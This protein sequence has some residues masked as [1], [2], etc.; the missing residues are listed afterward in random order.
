MRASQG[1]TLLE[2]V[3]VFALMMGLMLLIT[4]FFIKGQRYATASEAYGSTQRQATI[5]LGR[6]VDELHK[7]SRLHLMVGPSNDEIAAISFAD[8]EGTGTGTGQ[9]EVQFDTSTGRLVWKK[10]VAFYHDEPSRQVRR[11]ETPLPS[12]TTDLAA[13]PTP[14]PDFPSLRSNPQAKP[15]GQDVRDFEVGLTATGASL[16]VTVAKQ[17]PLTMLKEAEKDVSVTVRMDIHMLD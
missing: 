14:L 6:I 5:L 8:P 1:L 4:A 17:L 12:T 7:A 16:T 3:L 13:A 11:V 2:A 9:A 15:I 10:W